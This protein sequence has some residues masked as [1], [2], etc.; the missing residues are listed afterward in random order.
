MIL[1][2]IKNKQKATPLKYAI[3]L[4]WPVT[5][6]IK[7]LL[8]FIRKYSGPIFFISVSFTFIYI[9]APLLKLNAENLGGIRII[10]M[11]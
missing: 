1:K 5:I 3:I 2:V 6:N 9:L 4:I 11:L 7:N 10:L 8:I